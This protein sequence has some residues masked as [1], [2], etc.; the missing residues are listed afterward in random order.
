MLNR[1]DPARRGEAVECLRA[2]DSDGYNIPTHRFQLPQT[3]AK[4]P[5]P[6]ILRHLGEPTFVWE[7]AA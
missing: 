4:S 5:G 3:W 2:G 1:N 6:I 7:R